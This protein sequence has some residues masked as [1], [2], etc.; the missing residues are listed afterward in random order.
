[1]DFVTIDFE[2]AN[3]DPASVCAVGMAVV[4]NY[5]V[6][7]TFYSLIRPLQKEFYPRNIRIHGITE[8]MVANAPTFEEIY[9]EI[10]SH[11]GN[12]PLVAHNATFDMGV[13]TKS[14]HQISC[15]VPD[16]DYI[17][18]LQLCR[19][20]LPELPNHRLGAISR[21]LK[22]PIDHHNA[23]SDSIACAH[24]FIKLHKLARP[25][26]Q[27]KKLN[28]YTKPASFRKT[29]FTDNMALLENLAPN[30]SGLL[31]NI[32]NISAFKADSRF[33]GMR[34]VLTGEMD[35]LKRDQAIELIEHFGGWVT[36]S[37]SKKTD[38]VVVGCNEWD[39]YSKTGNAKTNKLKRAID[40][41]RQGCKVQILNQFD[42][43]EKIK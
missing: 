1:M 4:R 25:V 28:E 9:P 38:F 36:S 19:P 8:T 34:F 22:I 27:I 13:L 29:S 23:L 31:D 12:G 11:I 32:K 41:Q 40:F 24:L 14:L 42:F 18:T 39:I 33:E 43:F 5:S 20:L 30:V 3:N 21:L 2:T 37:V 7:D 6:V 35:L 16:V 26:I 17:C 10:C 15:P